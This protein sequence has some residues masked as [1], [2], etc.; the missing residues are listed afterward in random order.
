[1]LN[2]DNE[3]ELAYVVAIDDIKPIPGKD[4]VECAV[5]GGWTIMVRKDQFKPGDLGIYFEIDSKV[6]QVEP[7]LFL[8]KKHFAIKTQKYKAGD[9]HFWSQG[10][11]MSAEDFCGE[12]YTG[13]DGVQ[14]IH[15]NE[16]GDIHD[17]SFKEGDFLTKLLGV[18]YAIA[19]DN[20]RKRATRD[21]YK[22]MAR[23]Q[24]K[25][26]SKQPYKWLMNRLW[27]KK[28]LFLFFGK[29]RDKNRWPEWVVKTDE[30]RVQNMPWILEDKETWIVT[31]KIDGTSTTFT[32]KRKRFG[33][34]DFYVCSRNVMFDCPDTPC[35]YD[36]NVY[37]EMAK[38]YDIENKMKSLMENECS[39]C[40]WITIQGETYGEGIQKR[41]YSCDGHLFA[42]FNFITSKDGRYNSL[43]MQEILQTKHGIPCVPILRTDYILPDTIEK[44][45]EFATGDSVLD[46]KPREGFVFR[47][48]DGERSFKA[49]SNEYLM[50]YHG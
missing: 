2:K 30:E 6:P 4:R 1:M 22:E 17:K 40:E 50:K 48:L 5:V 19:N 26:F 7:F 46:A 45:I 21:K 16:W 36:A 31:E 27:G 34:Y 39:D 41:D 35:Y 20:R 10:L 33:G 37:L 14:Y 43:D 11:L 42:A 29:K 32:M 9:G 12:T 47:S 15:I 44:V 25:R 18:T 49:V 38:M 28:L 24:G 23:R 8:E 3:R 13:E